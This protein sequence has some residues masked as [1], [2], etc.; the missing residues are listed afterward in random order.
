MFAFQIKSLLLAWEMTSTIKIVDTFRTNK[1]GLF[2]HIIVVN[3]L[4]A[5]L[6]RLVLA[7]S[8]TCNCFNA[9]WM[10]IQWNAIDS[11]WALYCEEDVGPIVGH[12][13]GGDSRRFELMLKDYTSS[14]GTQFVI[15]WPGWVMTASFTS[16]G[17]VK[18]LHNQDYINN[19]K[20]LINPLDSPVQVLQLGGDV[21]C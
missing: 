5:N 20:K 12:A 6:P 16:V 3:P 17:Y 9:T 7:L 13:N 1:M 4:H 2:T 14:V 8:C 21:C 11:L 18:I 15:D 10:R 19:G